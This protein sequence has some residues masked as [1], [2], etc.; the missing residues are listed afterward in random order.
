M[1]TLPEQ[2]NAQLLPQG[3]DTAS[4]QPVANAEKIRVARTTNP[5]SGGNSV[6][7]WIGHLMGRTSGAKWRGD[8]NTNH[9]YAQ[10]DIVLYFAYFR[11]YYICSIAHSGR[12]PTT[13]HDYWERLNNF[14]SEWR[15]GRQYQAGEI[16]VWPTKEAPTQVLLAAQDVTGTTDVATPAAQSG[17]ITLA[18]Q[19]WHGAWDANTTYQSGEFVAYSDTNYQALAQ[20]INVRPDRD[21]TKWLAISPWLAS[22]DPLATYVRGAIVEWSNHIWICKARTTAAVEP[23]LANSA[24]WTLLTGGQGTGTSTWRGAWSGS[25]TYNAGDMVDHRGLFVCVTDNYQHGV[26]PNADV[27]H[28]RPVNDYKGDWQDTWYLHG[29]LV[30]R[31]GKMWMA[32]DFINQGDAAPDAESNTKWLRV[33]NYNATEIGSIVDTHVEAWA[34]IGGGLIPATRIESANSRYHGDWSTASGP[35]GVGDV[36]LN[37]PTGSDNRSFWLC[38]KAHNKRS[39]RPDQDSSVYWGR[40]M[41]RH[42]EYDRIPAA[43]PGA[44]KVWKTDGNS[45]PGWRDD[46]AGSGG[47]GGLTQNQ[48]DARIQ[49]L[50]E[51][52]AE[53]G[54]ST[55][56]PQVK[57]ANAPFTLP[58][59]WA[60]GTSY[61]AGDYVFHES[62]IYEAERSQSGNN[63]ASDDGTNWA[64]RI[65][66][67]DAAGGSGLSQDQVDARV[68]AGVEDW[69]EEGDTSV[70]PAAKVPTQITAAEKARIPSASP[71]NNKVWKT[72]GSGD[73][74]W[75]DDATGSGGTSGDDAA[76]WAEEGDTS[77]IPESKLTNAP[78]RLPPDWSNTTAYSAGDHVLRYAVIYEAA[79]D[80]TGN[81]PSADDGTNWSAV[82]RGTDADQFTA[83]RDTPATRT[84]GQYLRERADN[85]GLEFAPSEFNMPPTWSAATSYATGEYVVRDS[86]IYESRVSNNLNNQPSGATDAN[87]R[88]QLIGTD[89]VGAGGTGGLSQ[90]EVDARVRAGVH[91]WAE[92]DDSTAIP[93]SKAPWRPPP[94]WATGTSYAAGAYVLRSSVIYEAARANSGNDPASDTGTNWTVVLRGTDTDTGD[95][96]RYRGTWAAGIYAV[97]DVVLHS[98]DHYLCTTARTAANTSNPATNTTAWR[99]VSLSST[100]V[101]ALARIPD[102]TSDANKV[103]KTDGSG[104]PGWRDDAEASGGMGDDAASWAESG[105]TDSIPSSKLDNAPFRLPPAWASGTTYAAGDYALRNEIIWEAAQGNTGNDP[106]ADDGSNWTAV[107]RGTDTD[108]QR[109]N[110]EIDAR[111]TAGVSDWAEQGNTD[112]IP[113]SKLDDAPYRLPAQWG[114]GTTYEAGAFV[115]NDGLIYQAAVRNYAIEP[116]VT[117]NWAG[118]WNFVADHRRNPTPGDASRYRGAW[119][120]GTA[121]AVGEI[122]LHSSRHYV[123][124]AARSTSVTDNPDTDT[125]S[126]LQTT[127]T[128]AE[129]SA[130]SRIPSASPGNNKVWKS[131]GSGTPGWRDDADTD[132]LIDLTDTPSTWG[133]ASQ[134]LEKDPDTDALQWADKPLAMPANSTP[135][136]NLTTNGNGVIAWRRQHVYEGQIL[137]LRGRGTGNARWRYIERHDDATN[138]GRVAHINGDLFAWCRTH[139]PA[140]TSG[141]YERSQC[142]AL[143]QG[144]PWTPV[145]VEDNDEAATSHGS[146]LVYTNWPDTANAPT[147]QGVEVGRDA[148]NYLLVWAT[149]SADRFMRVFYYG[150]P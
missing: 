37:D 142:P 25:A 22:Y 76:A 82:F 77:A 61:S 55:L 98:S 60:T 67:T 43:S 26:G 131:N 7:D 2:S 38:L 24:H 99:R 85:T 9:S 63:P 114:A 94:D 71:G 128:A 46:D 20:S 101:A 75:R 8:W 56:I 23:T 109:S 50:V 93:A 73:P 133:T 149:W 52:W 44:N 145:R 11:K 72:D 36:V 42:S 30:R 35:F 121:Y 65:I 64:V 81:S 125:A 150:N 130:I 87:W 141:N 32:G 39:N 148:N 89:Q 58:P 119:A 102:A 132:A 129:V 14:D 48:V 31:S 27:T 6:E 92:A 17:W 62:I 68:R 84:A 47:T 54:D 96:T 100:E 13:N 45:V 70:I 19:P 59:T 15:A 126:W 34:Q 139:D 83:L 53:V 107:F 120:S 108:T 80:N 136:Q 117:A 21:R 135:Y 110:T 118:S 79:I 88:V 86:I 140:A 49:A 33:N 74:G 134:I 90:A 104:N 40:G 5:P 112:S 144:F 146:R 29:S 3:I 18:R 10:G 105:N 103:W 111:V 91:D 16:V 95:P 78:F 113:E 1:P 41:L 124:V 12:N 123:C 57:L 116:G 115:M 127:L 4:K 97:G 28:W 137:R 122:V 143:F 66:G 51:N 147:F 106:S 138:T 69:A